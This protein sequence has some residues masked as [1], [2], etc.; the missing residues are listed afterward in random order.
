ME[1]LLEFASTA[2]S[3]ALVA[4]GLLL[5]QRSYGL[6]LLEIIPLA[7]GM[8]LFVLSSL[9]SDS[10]SVLN[11]ST[12]LIPIAGC[13]L[14]IRV[15]EPCYTRWRLRVAGESSA[16]LISFAVMNCGLL[17][18][19]LAT[20]SRSVA[21]GLADFRLIETKCHLETAVV[22]LCIFAFAAAVQYLR[23]TRLV[24]A[25]QLSKDDSRL[26]A[27]FGRDSVKTRRHVLLLAIIL[28]TAGVML[29]ISLQE[30]FAVLNCYSIL[31][32]SFAIAISQSRIRVGRLVATAFVLTV[33][34]ELLTQYTSELLRDFH[35]AVLFSFFVVVGVSLRT[36][37]L[38]GVTTA[39]QRRLR[40]LVKGIEH[41][42]TC[43]R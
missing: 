11:A 13:A 9:H 26:L 37:Q 12:L 6:A 17:V 31:V 2:L 43:S 25:L 27:T 32:P 16:L 29:F 40:D 39:C 36:A 8:A 7:T 38:T 18:M 20:S 23:R 30:T 35:Q 21:I 15:L 34:R 41:S 4:F 1:Y 42:A 5:V 33:L 19:S 28:C 24:A 10:P 3:I 14:A 22:A